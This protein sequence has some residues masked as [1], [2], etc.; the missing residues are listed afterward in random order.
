MKMRPLLSCLFFFYNLYCLQA[1][2][3]FEKEVDS[4]RYVFYYDSTNVDGYENCVVRD[5]E[6]FHRQSGERKYSFLPEQV[7]LPCEWFNED[8]AVVEDMNFDGIPDIR[9]LDMMSPVGFP[10]FS[11]YIFQPGE[12][13]FIIDTAYQ[14]NLAYPNFDHEKEI[15]YSDWVSAIDYGTDIFKLED[16]KL[17]LVE[18]VM[19][20]PEESH[21]G[22]YTR[23]HQKRIDGVMKIIKRERISEQQYQN[24]E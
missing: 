4:L 19:V 24:R 13:R 2:H 14:N 11:Y 23:L 1:Q 21:T 16:G 3:S 10:S 5:V 18:Q 22:Y 6:I 8:L 20:Y 12:K 7:D 9:L 15:I 17:L